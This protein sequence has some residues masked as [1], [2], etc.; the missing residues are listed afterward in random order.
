[1]LSGGLAHPSADF[2]SAF[3]IRLRGDHRSLHFRKSTTFADR[4][5]ADLIQN[6]KIR[7]R[8]FTTERPKEP[9]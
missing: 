2:K 8:N 9:L 6:L 3:A 5:I 1:M 4:T 7:Q